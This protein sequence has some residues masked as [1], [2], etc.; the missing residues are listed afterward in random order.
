MSDRWFPVGAERCFPSFARPFP[1]TRLPVAFPVAF[2]K[3]EGDVE[4]IMSPLRRQSLGGVILHPGLDPGIS[5][6]FFPQEIAGQ[7]RDEGNK[8]GMRAR[9]PE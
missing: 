3:G 5:S 6:V 7:A 1:L 8:P 2:P 4:G 9:R